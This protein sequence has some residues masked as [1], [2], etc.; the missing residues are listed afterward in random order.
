[1]LV[2][3]EEEADKISDLVPLPHNA[4]PRT[5][6][7]IHPTNH[8]LTITILGINVEKKLRNFVPLCFVPLPPQLSRRISS[9]RRQPGGKVFLI[10][11]QAYILANFLLS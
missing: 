9:G 8:H 2:F 7:N 6:I 10:M 3:H 11:Q 1:M 4:T 5:L